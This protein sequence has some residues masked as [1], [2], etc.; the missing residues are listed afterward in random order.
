MR[1]LF[2]AMPNSIHTARWLNVI[3]DSGWDI[4]LF[5][6][7]EAILHPAA[8]N[9][10]WHWYTSGRPA[11]VDP[12]VQIQ[13]FWPVPFGSGTLSMLA[14]RWVPGVLNYSRWLARVIRQIKPDIVHSLEFQHAGYLTLAAHRLLRGRFPPWI[15]MNWGSDIYCFGRLA[16]HRERIRA[17]LATCDYYS[18]ECHRDVALARGLGFDGK[19]LPVLPA[20][21][22][23]DL[24]SVAPFRSSQPPSQRRLILLK[25][26][27]TWAG[28]ALVGLRAIEM[29]ADEL[30]GYRVAIYSAVPDVQLAAELVAHDTGIPIDIIPP[31]SHENMLRLF[32]Q[33]RVYIGLSISDGISTSLLEALTM[34]A[35]PIQSNTAC[36]DEWLQNG[37][38]GFIVP[39]EDPHRVAAALRRALRDDALVDSAARQNALMVEERLDWKVLRPK[40]IDM[41]EDVYR[42]TKQVRDNLGEPSRWGQTNTSCK[43]VKTALARFQPAG[44]PQQASLRE[45]G[46]V[47]G[48]K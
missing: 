45:M 12:S 38:T 13:S 23:L 9:V 42:Q 21:A 11:S 17:V 46:P 29:C 27:Q 31:G 39:P 36:A 19:V 20:C 7:Y 48:G 3:A 15:A 8:R 40:M 18:C 5:P 16:A 41:Y 22:G 43:Q 24:A 32:G 10:T 2:V 28:R 44:L 6:A 30:R 1:I 35:F 25:G 4:H 26:Y 33:A 37:R 34:G 14:R 47:P